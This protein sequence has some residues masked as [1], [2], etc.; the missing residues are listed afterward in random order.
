MADKR[1]EQNFHFIMTTIRQQAIKK[2]FR[3]QL[4]ISQ[5]EEM[6]KNGG[7]HI[8]LK[9]M[10]KKMQANAPPIDLSSVTLDL[11]TFKEFMNA[12][13]DMKEE[14]FYRILPRSLNF[15][16][17]LKSVPEECEFQISDLFYDDFMMF[18]YELQ[19]LSKKHLFAD[20]PASD[21]F[22]LGRHP[23]S[24][25]QGMPVKDILKDIKKSELYKNRENEKEE[26]LRKC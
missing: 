21:L 8:G 16:D 7:K 25:C 1:A 6:K 11:V 22:L 23:L 20:D 18:R 12:L 26:L 2:L 24:K 15:A 10:K 9:E 13:K 14:L 5:A 3:E 19:T 17:V 4:R